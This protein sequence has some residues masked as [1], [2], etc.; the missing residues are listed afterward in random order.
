MR[1]W[2]RRSIRIVRRL[3]RF[4]LRG[5]GMKQGC[6][7]LLVV[8]LAG[9]CA[10]SCESVHLPWSGAT[11][12]QIK[13]DDY[14]DKLKAGWI[15]QMAG[16]GWGG[17][18]EFQYNGEIMPPEAVPGWTPERINQFDRNKFH[19]EATFL[20]ML[21]RSGFNAVTRQVGL[22][23]AG[24]GFPLWHA[25]REARNN[26]RAGIAP[27]DSGHPRF[28]SH[29]DDIDYQAECDFVGLI[30]PG[31]PA[32]AV[33][34]GEKFGR[35]ICYGDGLYGGQFV[36]GMY[37]EAFFEKDPA[38][39]VAAGL[40][41]IPRDSQ[42]HQCIS[43]VVRW[44][45]E[46]PDNWMRAWQQ[47]NRKYWLNPH[48][49]RFSCND[50][51]DPM[52]FDAKIN[53]A[54][55]VMGL[56]YGQGDPDA[57]ISIA[58]RCGQASGCNASTAAG[59]L[60]TSIGFRSLPEK[61]TSALDSSTKFSQTSYNF[62]TLIS[63][64]RSLAED[65]LASYGGRVQA[66]VDGRTS[67]VVPVRE[68]QVGP[69]QRSADAGSPAISRYKDREIIGLKVPLP[70]GLSQAVSQFAPGWEIADCGE[71]MTPGIYAMLRGRRN[72][73]VTCP[74]N[75]IQGCTLSRKVQVPTGRTTTLKLVVG[76]HP[77]GDWAL[78]VTANG[79][80]LVQ[81]T[82]GPA[83]TDLGWTEITVDLSSYAGQTI[84]LQLLNLPT[85]WHY[86]A[87]YWAEISLQS[88]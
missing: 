76:H 63:V 53:G 4:D 5:Y 44:H 55:V 59:V 71:Q 82:I 36:A 8:V 25:N 86:E 42:Y 17:P 20:R 40:R 72:V 35:M 67:F 49:R 46:Y 34:L 14:I 11:V 84:D 85:G 16:V 27:P 15:G 1:L 83:V 62:P 60:F 3:G 21:D 68:P 74:P 32:A 78:A 23:F 61:F 66:D 39:I 88:I 77:K 51:N 73:L 31:M 7:M 45:S 37:T 57:T 13:V 30:A 70:A 6:V 12:R 41:C 54:F 58:T 38:R 69:A 50:A 52:D 22:D 10:V 19:V 9:L 64:C 33:Q 79:K 56:L 65:T 24:T 81:K 2:Q 48:Y 80:P 47:I 26:L 18:T 87:G 75:P 43:D 28:N 29:A